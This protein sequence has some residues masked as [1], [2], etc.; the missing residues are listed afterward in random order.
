MGDIFT[1]EI[2]AREGLLE[3]TGRSKSNSSTLT[4]LSGCAEPGMSTFPPLSGR[5]SI[6]RALSSTGMCGDAMASTIMSISEP[7]LAALGA[8]ERSE[9]TKDDLDE[10]PEI[11]SRALGDADISVERGRRKENRLPSPRAESTRSWP[12]SCS[13]IRATTANPSPVEQVRLTG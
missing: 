9:R 7:L 5:D 3:D 13:T 11:D 6:V 12:P 8:T 2:F 1:G 10:L 4:G